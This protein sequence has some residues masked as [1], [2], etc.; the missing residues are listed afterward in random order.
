[1]REGCN[2]FFGLM[3]VA[4]GTLSSH[5]SA[6]FEVVLAT[7]PQWVINVVLILAIAL[8]MSSADTL[9]NGMASVFT[10]GGQIKCQTLMKK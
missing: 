10:A 6:L 9:I 4:E 8:V 7:S 5:S 3:A 1:M 2:G